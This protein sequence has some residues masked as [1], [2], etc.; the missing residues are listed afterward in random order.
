MRKSIRLAI[1][2]WWTVGL[3]GLTRADIALPDDPGQS[4]LSDV[5]PSVHIGLLSQQEHQQLL[6]LLGER[7]LCVIGEPPPPE[8]MPPLSSKPE[9]RNPKLPLSSPSPEV[10]KVAELPGAGVSTEPLR[11]PEPGMFALLLLGGAAVLG[12]GRPRKFH[13]ARSA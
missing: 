8:V 11:V 7:T 13:P 3:G 5:R 12:F 4:Y 2:V 9:T 10:W 6:S 1:A